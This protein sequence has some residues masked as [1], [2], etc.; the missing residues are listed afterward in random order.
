MFWQ[1]LYACEFQPN[2][3]QP[4]FWRRRRIIICAHARGGTSEC[5]CVTDHARTDF[6]TSLLE[7]WILNGVCVC[8]CGL[9][10]H[11]HTQKLLFQSNPKLALLWFGCMRANNTHSRD[12]DAT[13]IR[14]KLTPRS[15]STFK[16]SIWTQTAQPSSAAQLILPSNKH[17]FTHHAAHV[18]GVVGV[19]RIAV[20]SAPPLSTYMYVYLLRLENSL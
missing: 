3:G 19:H 17:I 5:L 20:L 8:V 2:I 18:M 7:C 14:Y 1:Y 12:D 13:V 11:I 15:F 10:M 9:R 6:A 4:D 16:T